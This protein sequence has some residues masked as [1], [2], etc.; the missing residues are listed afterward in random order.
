MGTKTKGCVVALASLLGLF[1]S[2]ANTEMT[3]TWTD[4][5]AKGAA[6][7]R[8]A[9]ICLAKDEGLRRMAEDQ[10]TRGV[11]NAQVVPSYQVL[12]GIDLKDK[13]AV[14]AKLSAAG[15]QGVLVMQMTGV[16]QELRATSYSTFDGYY[17]YAYPMAY[18]PTYLE[19]YPVVHVQ[20][21]LYSLPDG[22]LIWS[23]S[24]RTFDPN[25]AK[26]VVDDVSREVGKKLEKERILI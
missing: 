19:S 6:L 21:N 15:F 17:G 11:Q 13:D 3:D 25:S 1:A 10:V 8:I 23:G 14:K 22:K 2:C 18:G 9:V 20:S 16:S 4:P 5:S 26:D 24:S 7:Q 12:A